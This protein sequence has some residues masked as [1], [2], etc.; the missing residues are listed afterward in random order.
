MCGVNL[1]ENFKEMGHGLLD[2]VLRYQNNELATARGNWEERV[3]LKVNFS[4][5][6]GGFQLKFET[7]V[8]KTQIKRCVRRPWRMK[9]MI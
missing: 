6:Q 5:D 7:D 2:C 9:G 3:L 1:V 8:G 4:P